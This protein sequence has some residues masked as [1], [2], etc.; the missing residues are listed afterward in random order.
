MMTKT[1]LIVTLFVFCLSCEN[2]KITKDESVFYTCSMD[3]QVVSDKPGNCPICGMPLTLV[4]K[5]AVSNADDIALSDQQIQLGNIVVDTIRKGNINKEIEF[6]GTLNLN[7]S[8]L[9]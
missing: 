8:L 4:K 1:L 7:A 6:T 9:G 5:S 3:P 2:E